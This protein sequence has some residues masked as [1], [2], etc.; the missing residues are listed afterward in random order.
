[1]AIHSQDRVDNSPLTHNENI[2]LYFSQRLLTFYLIFVLT[3]GYVLWRA[4]IVTDFSNYFAMSGF[5]PMNASGLAA[6]YAAFLCC[7]PGKR[8]LQ[9]SILLGLVTE[10]LYQ[11]LVL[12][13]DSTFV[14]RLLTVGGGFGI[15][16]LLCL[17]ALF[18]QQR[19]PNAKK[20][21]KAY[22][23]AGLCIL[24]YP[25]V[26]GKGIGIL[27]LMTPQVY[28]SSVFRF[29]SILG[30]YP[31]AEISKFLLDHSP[32]LILTHAVYARLPLFIFIGFLISCLRPEKSYFNI[33][34]AFILGG[35]LAFP[36]Y[37]LLPMVGIDHY[38]GSP[39]W[40]F[41]V[42]PKEDTFHLVNAP[43]SLP[44]TC[45][46][47]LHA[48]WIALFYFSTCRVSLKVR[49]TSVAIVILTILGSLSHSVGHYI[50]DTFVAI[51]FSLATIALSTPRTEKNGNSRF[52]SMVFGLGSILG[53]GV[54]FA[55]FPNFAYDFAPFLWVLLALNC[56]A[57]PYLESRLAKDSLP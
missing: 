4:Q 18:F 26:A 24:F 27:S 50:V 28:D 47:S 22:L 53:W 44:R 35:F 54:L 45:F 25:V 37:F 17:A 15:S 30:V 20:R 29:T 7:R 34:Q 33:L 40:P 5:D 42:F 6:L 31:A 1:M 41:G 13:S 3:L 56:L 38:L 52:I 14:N 16:G 11:L 10:V 49:L 21:V 23:L 43:L 46:P 2:L 12:P 36:I 57:T 55:F 51:P 32:L 9:L 19:D 8:A 39:P 48:A